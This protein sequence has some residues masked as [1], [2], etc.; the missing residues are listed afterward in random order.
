MHSLPPNPATRPLYER[1]AQL[2]TIGAWECHLANETLTWTDGVYD[3]FGLRRGGEIQRSAILDLY[4]ERS[5]RE[6]DRLRT[7]A[8]CGGQGFALDCRILTA[9]GEKRWMRLVV[10]VGYQHGRPYRIF[11]SK[12]D[13]TA[14]KGLWQELAGIARS[15]TL[16]G[17]SARHGLTEALHRCQPEHSRER[18]ALVLF[19]IDGFGAIRER[20]GRPAGSAVDRCIAERLKRLFSDA[21]AIEQAGEGAYSLLLRMPGDR[22]HL[23]AA[24]DS[25]RIL[26]GRPVPHG[27]L[28]LDFTL[29]I[30]GAL[31]VQEGGR[32]PQELFAEA[33]AALH[34]AGT[35]GGNCVRIFDGPVAAPGPPPARAC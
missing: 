13:V 30:G 35:A 28:V 34:V 10:G 20:F 1:A 23:L 24:L 12:Q 4:E 25:V 5:R 27:A 16:S 6:M 2:G 22:H 29:S 11:G 18:I 19:A 26:L 15:E 7:S 17:F 9:G 3:L 31:G 32:M 33:E 21:L 8:I 14:E